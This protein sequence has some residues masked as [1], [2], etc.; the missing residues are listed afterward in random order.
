MHDTELDFQLLATEV[1]AATDNVDISSESSAFIKELE[2]LSI[3]V[4][5]ESG[6]GK[7]TLINALFGRV[8]ADAR[9]GSPVQEHVVAHA[10]EEGKLTILDTPGFEPEFMQRIFSEIE[11]YLRKFASSMGFVLFVASPPRVHNHHIK[12]LKLANQLDVPIIICLTR[13]HK[14]NDQD[15]KYLD[16]LKNRIK[17]ESITR[18][19]AVVD[20]QAIDIVIN[21]DGKK[22]YKVRLWKRRIIAC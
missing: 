21:I 9:P 22:T 18:V 8:V 20:T 19:S 12:F 1:E 17:H 10:V 15:K 3:L 5:G 7:S 6:V 4:A 2:N 11:D 16:E 13:Y 14:D